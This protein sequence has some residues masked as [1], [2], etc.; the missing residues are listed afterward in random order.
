[1]N[2]D[3]SYLPGPKVN[4]RYDISTMTRWRW[5]HNETLNFP[6]PLTI[7]R[8]KFWRLSEL[9]SWEATRVGANKKAAQETSSCRTQNSSYKESPSNHSPVLTHNLRLDPSGTSSP[10]TEQGERQCKPRSRD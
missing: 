4:S 3:D 10:A 7:N 1:V 8:R 5:E 6:K 9:V 2:P